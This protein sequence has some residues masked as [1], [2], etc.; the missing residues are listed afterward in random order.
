MRQKHAQEKKLDKTQP[1]VIIIIS[2]ESIEQ[3][4]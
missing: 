4:E 2:I 3:E 1:P